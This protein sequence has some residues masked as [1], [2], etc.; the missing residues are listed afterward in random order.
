M[1]TERLNYGQI[2]WDNLY[3]TGSNSF[4]R[5]RGDFTQNSNTITNITDQ[6]SPY[7]GFSHVL[8]GQRLISSGNTNG[9][10]T[11]TDVDTGNN[12]ITIDS[13]AVANNS[14]ALIRVSPPKGQYFIESGSLSI[15]GNSQFSIS[16]ITGS[17][18][19]NFQTGDKKYGF[20]VQLAST[21]SLSSGMQDKYGQYV[22]TRIFQQE[23]GNNRLSFYISASDSG[24]NGE[25]ADLA[26]TT[27][28]GYGLISELSVSQSLSSTLFSN[29]LSML[30]GFSDA[31]YQVAVANVIDDFVTDA[32]VATNGFPY[33]GSAQ[34]LGSLA[35]TGSNVIQTRTGGTDFFVIKSGSLENFKFN[36]EGVAQFYAYTSSYTPTPVLGGLYFNSQSA[37]IGVEE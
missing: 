10:A 8:V 32:G 2:T 9:T 7:E 3:A 26:P 20:I 22:I 15:P 24:V 35:V 18:D 36:G 29:D 30:G 27:G 14:S 23:A 34:I 1:A 12:T 25:P 19:S 33:T 21:S 17:E 11:I 13:N 4:I 6:G 5:I 31:A 16:N 37:Y 28:L